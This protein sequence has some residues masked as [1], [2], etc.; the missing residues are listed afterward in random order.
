M[1]I[2]WVVGA[3]R[4]QEVDPADPR[5]A[6]LEE[7]AG[8]LKAKARSAWGTRNGNAPVPVADD[9]EDEF[10]SRRPPSSGPLDR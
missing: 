1:S 3:R 6:L 9:I 4:W 10:G 8:S 2:V 7:V 5:K